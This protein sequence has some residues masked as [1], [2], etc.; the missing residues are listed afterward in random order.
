MNRRSFTK[1]LAVSVVAL[2]LVTPAITAQSTWQT[3]TVKVE[4][5]EAAKRIRFV[6]ATKDG[7]S[8]SMWIELEYNF[9]L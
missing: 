5:F 6:P 7:Q 9:N 8:V 1:I 3:Y 2:L 4:G